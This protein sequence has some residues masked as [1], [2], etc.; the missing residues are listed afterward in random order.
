MIAQNPTFPLDGKQVYVLRNDQWSEARLMGWQWSSQ[1]GEKYT[2]LYLE[3]NAR[4]EG[5]SIERIR[6]LEEMQNAGIETNVY[7]L[8]S[9]AGIEQMLATHNKWREQVG[10]PPL[11]WSPRLANYA[12]EWADKLLRENSFEHRQNSN[13]GENLAAASGQQLSPER[14]VNMWGS[15][16][17]YYDY[18]TNSC[19]PGK[20][21]GHY[22]QVVWEDTQE[23]GCGMARN[24][25]R[26]VWVCNY[27]PPGNYV[28]EKPY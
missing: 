18:A 14:V 28:G 7:D 26:E 8:N 13:Y 12:Q 6:S 1:D 20:V 9:Q 27:N 2:V 3:D 24:E 15:E 11:Q 23:V 22:T 4:E 5:V 16:V 25:N 19:S 10:V 17:E 21:C